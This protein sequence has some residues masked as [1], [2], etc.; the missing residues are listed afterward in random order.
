MQLPAMGYGLRYEY[1]IFRQTI[2]DGWQQE[3]PDN[4]LRHPDP[5]EVARPNETVEVKLNCSFELQSGSLR[6]IA[7]RPSTSDRRAVRSAGGG[8]RRQD[9][10]HTASLGRGDSTITSISRSSA[11]AISSARWPK[12]SPPNRVTRVL[13]PDDSTSMG[14]GLRFVQ[15]YFLVACSLADLIRRFRREQR[16]LGAASR[17][18]RD[19][20]QRHASGDGRSRADANPARRSETRLGPGVGPHATD[21][22]LHESHAA[23]RGARKMAD[24]LV[25]GDACRGNWRSST[26]SIGGSS[27]TVRERFPDD[28]GRLAASQ[29]D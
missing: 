10:Q 15:E 13:Y 8:L 2:R 21:A 22:G 17:K 25:R 7:G 18:G 20:A 4:W 24:R 3:Q 26:K 14:Q 28:Q 27:T 16:R 12:R 23:A 6:A 5:W 9:D 1:G 29:L 11:A 19:P